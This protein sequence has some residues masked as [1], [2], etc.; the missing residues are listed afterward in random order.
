MAG[1]EPPSPFQSK[2]KA[3]TAVVTA[4]TVASLVVFDWD[5]AT[6]HPTVFSGIKPALRRQ[7]NRL[8]GIDERRPPSSPSPPSGPAA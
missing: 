2:V 8:Y 7:I 6:G 1:I 5:K 3:W 4:L